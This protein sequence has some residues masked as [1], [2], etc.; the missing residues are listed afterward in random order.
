MI[1]QTLHTPPITLEESYCSEIQPTKLMPFLIEEEL[2][3]A[4]KLEELS[5]VFEGRCGNLSEV[6]TR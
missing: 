1:Y 4:G 5:F 2:S 6:E 3:T